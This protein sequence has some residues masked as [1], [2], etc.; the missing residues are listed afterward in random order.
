MVGCYLSNYIMS[1][2]RRGGDPPPPPQAPGRSFVRSHHEVVFSLGSLSI[3]PFPALS[4]YCLPLT[5]CDTSSVRARNDFKGGA[6]EASE[7]AGVAP[8]RSHITSNW[9]SV[10]M[11][12]RR[13]AWEQA[14]AS[15]SE[16]AHSPGE[17]GRSAQRAATA[18]L[19][20][21]MV[22]L[23][24]G[25]GKAAVALHAP[26]ERH[27]CHYGG[28]GPGWPGLAHSEVLADTHTGYTR[29]PSWKP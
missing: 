1:R 5:H 25:G 3:S 11:M 18:H 6:R 26:S 22:S 14:A 10:E 23:I 28:A 24:A 2:A 21:R 17:E 4:F 29:R 7:P 20:R 19:R 13:G 9:N 12:F 8:Q 27:P 15:S 16:Q